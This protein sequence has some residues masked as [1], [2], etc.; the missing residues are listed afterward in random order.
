MNFRF[1][2]LLSIL[3][4][5]AVQSSVFANGGGLLATTVQETYADGSRIPLTQ[6]NKVIQTRDGYIWVASYD[7]LFRY[8]GKQTKLFT[9]DDGFPTRS[10]MTVFEDTRDRLWIGTNNAGLVMFDGKAEFTTITLADGLPS[11]SIRAIVEDRTGTIYASTTLGLVAIT[12]DMNIRQIRVPGQNPLFVVRMAVTPE[13][14]VWCVLN[15]GAVIVLREGRAVRQF[16][17]RHFAQA[18]VTTVFHSTDGTIY[19]GTADSRIILLA[20]DGAFRVVNTETR[21]HANSFY[22]DKS[23]RVWL[24]SDTGMGYFSQGRFQAMDGALIESALQNMV[25]DFEGN[26]W[27]ASSRKGLLQ[28][29]ASSFT[30][31][32]VASSLPPLIVNATQLY[33]GRLYIGADEG[34][35]ILDKNGAATT[36][37][38]T[39][40]LRGIRIR[41][42]TADAEGNLWICTFSPYGL[43]RYRDDGTFVSISRNSHGLPSDKVRCAIPGMD[44]RLLAGT[45][46][47]LS[48]IK[49]DTVVKSYTKY[50]GLANPVI[51]NLLEDGDG[52]I[53]AGSDGGGIFVIHDDAVANYTEAHGLTSGIIM[54]MKHDPD[55]GGIWIS[56]ENGLCYWDEA[57]IRPIEKLG[58]YGVNIF[59]MQFPDKDTLWLLSSG[60]VY[61]AKRKSL[62]SPAPLEIDVLQRRDGLS[63][64]ITANAWNTV[65]PEGVLYLATNTGVLSVAM[66][67][68]E[69]HAVAPKLLISS[70]IADER[71]IS[72]PDSVDLPSDTSRLTINFSLISYKYPDGNSVRVLLEG[73]DREAQHISTDQ[74]SRVSYT[75][76]PGGSYRLVVSG[77]NRDGVASPEIIL[78]IHKEK[79]FL[80]RPLVRALFMA[81]FLALFTLMALLYNRYKTRAIL[82]R[83]QEYR[84]IT[85]QAIKAIA[86]TI[87][88]KDR[89][90]SGHSKRVAAYSLEIAKRLGMSPKRQE[91]LY[92]A[93][94]LHDI[95][96]VGIEDHI[97]NKEGCLT[98]AEYDK[99]KQHVNVGG[100]ILRSIT[101]IKD[102]AIGARYHHESFDGNGYCAGLKGDEIPLFARIICV[103]DAYDAMSTTRSYRRALSK[104]DIF[105]EL[106]KGA[107]SQF[108][109][110]IVP[111]MIS[112]VNEGKR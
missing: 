56:T 2:F 101:V 19:L 43:I 88:A 61:I 3:L 64:T 8:D 62:L 111:I 60:G 29:I 85:T 35:F 54:R 69:K 109:S 26:L 6:A 106:T 25:E 65:S 63:A 112:I 98:D 108:D 14:E 92:Y 86:D 28:V 70:V 42:L 57:G 31:V 7:G 80:E 77:V 9:A 47:G 46:E 39:R 99:V 110:A 32:S 89:Y 78:P 72:H 34:L 23:G 104:E 17:P 16:P 18:A 81:A 52:R 67:E 71:E 21:H 93:A 91:D 51:M 1:I 90:T 94:L 22:E 24:C 59:D 97:L 83:Q 105:R 79:H 30:N 15:S 76:L 37:E 75:N 73:F 82:Q 33:N 36:D 55:L 84:E 27:F 38:L 107:G 103:A 44:G 96:K 48:V 40:R 10:I 74:A 5:I 87:D 49:N 11:S 4:C 45:A 53:Y 66:A 68:V 100:E 13:N 95:G 12:P 102:I 50:D 41:S 20:P 58:K